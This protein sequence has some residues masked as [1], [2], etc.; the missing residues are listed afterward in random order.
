MS[1]KLYL[2]AKTILLA[3]R[4]AEL[5]RIAHELI[6]KELPIVLKSNRF[7]FLPEAIVGLATAKSSALIGS[8]QERSCLEC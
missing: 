8:D 1:D 5:E 7:S 3:S 2:R 6:E 4:R